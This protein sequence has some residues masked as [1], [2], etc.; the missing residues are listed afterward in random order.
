MIRDR[1]IRRGV[2]DEMKALISDFV[3]AHEVALIREFRALES[4]V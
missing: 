2:E 1:E 4:D 3:G